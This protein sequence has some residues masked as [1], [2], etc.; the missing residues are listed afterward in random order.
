M[1]SDRLRLVGASPAHVGRIA[2]RMREIDRIECGASGRSAKAALRLALRSSSWAI[3]ALVDGDPHA[4]FGVAPISLVQDRGSPWFLGSD[5]T[6]RYG[7]ALLE[8]GPDVIARM[9]ASFRRLE[10]TVSTGNGRALRLLSRWGF[11]IGDAPFEVSGVEFVRF[12]RE[13]NV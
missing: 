13:S 1:R 10:N 11:T 3:T 12:W 6:Y 5:E 8:L 4:M 7:R 9:H 2:Y